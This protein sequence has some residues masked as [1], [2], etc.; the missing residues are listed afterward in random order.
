MGRLFRLTRSLLRPISKFKGE[1]TIIV[2]GSRLR[3][4]V[5]DV[6][7]HSRE[8]ENVLRLIAKLSLAKKVGERDR[9]RRRNNRRLR[10]LFTHGRSHTAKQT[11][12]ERKAHVIRFSGPMRC[13][14]HLSAGG[15]H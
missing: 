7:I 15:R 14:P 9:L 8:V 1:R 5:L 3:P 2:S 13:G 6:R 4:L 10:E 11:S 12:E